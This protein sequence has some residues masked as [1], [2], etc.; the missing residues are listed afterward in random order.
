M[1]PVIGL[2]G[3]VALREGKGRDQ[4]RVELWQSYAAAVETAGGVPVLLPPVEGA[5]L[6]P[7]QLALVQGLIL[8]GG[9]DYD[10]ALYGCEPHPMTNPLHPLRVAY[11][12]K[13]ANAALRQRLP[14]LG[15]CGGL[16][17]VNIVLGGSLERHLPDLPDA[18]VQ[19]DG[20]PDTIAHEVAIAPDSRLAGIVG[21]ATL[22][23]N[24]SHHQ[25]AARLGRGLRVAARSTDGVIEAI[26]TDPAVGGFLLCVQWHPERL[27]GH[28]Q[29][30]ALFKALLAACRT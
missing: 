17:L 22:A 8:V 2:N 13:L 23:V 21:A 14:L 27:T 10:P 9:R 3:D 24:S 11:D 30:L 28:P 15:I 1:K 20:Q 26:E 29:H 19:H 4:P 7:A 25:A 18:T 6:I 16:Q 12:L 5:D